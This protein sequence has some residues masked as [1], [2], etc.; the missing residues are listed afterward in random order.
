M[1][2]EGIMRVDFYTYNTINTKKNRQNISMGANLPNFIEHVSKVHNL[3]NEKSF[4]K[5]RTENVLSLIKN[6]YLAT[7]TSKI[8]ETVKY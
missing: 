5:N 8:I 6:P 2:N 3:G 7:V 1:Y 4:V